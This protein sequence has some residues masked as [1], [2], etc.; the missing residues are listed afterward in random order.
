MEKILLDRLNH[1][2]SELAELENP[3]LGKTRGPIQQD[4]FYSLSIRIK[5]LNWLINKV[6]NG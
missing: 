5:E 3:K 1:L 6:K 4:P 2:K